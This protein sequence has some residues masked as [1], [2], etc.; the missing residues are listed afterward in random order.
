VNH[1]IATCLKQ[2]R[3]RQLRAVCLA[4]LASATLPVCGTP[5]DRHAIELDPWVFADAMALRWLDIERGQS[6]DETV[7]PIEQEYF[8]PS[9]L[10]SSPVSRAMTC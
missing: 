7:L 10:M 2:R 8:D 3:A 5:D 6:S 1:I 9:W 4:I